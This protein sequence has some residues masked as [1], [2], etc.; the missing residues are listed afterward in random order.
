M[1]TRRAW[2]LMF[3]F[4]GM[5]VMGIR[6]QAQAQAVQ[7]P[8]VTVISP[9]GPTGGGA[10]PPTTPIVPPPPVAISPL[11]TIGPPPAAAATSGPGSGS[12]GTVAPIGDPCR[13][14]TV[15]QKATIA[16]CQGR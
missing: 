12:P 5:A 13:N 16:L 15:E 10:A 1:R 6:A 11:T 14:L 7:P 2:A 8:S 3:G 4:A 9:S